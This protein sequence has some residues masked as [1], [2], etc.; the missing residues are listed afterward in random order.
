MTKEKAILAMKNGQRITHEYF[1]SDE[2]I[3]LDKEGFLRDEKDYHLNWI[4][5]WEIRKEWR[6]KGWSIYKK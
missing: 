5:F 6:N 4:E 2:F 1:S 3:Y